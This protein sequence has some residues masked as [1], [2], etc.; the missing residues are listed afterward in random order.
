M[1]PEAPTDVSTSEAQRRTL[2]LFVAA[3]A[4][5]GIGVL[6]GR[7]SAPKPLPAPSSVTVIRPTPSVITAL[8]DIAKL[9]SASCHVERVIDLKD[10]QTRFFG[11]IHAEDAILLIASGDVVA[12]VDLGKL[13]DGD[14]SVDKD[15]HKAT[16]RLPAPEILSSRLDNENTYVHTRSTD[17][18]AQRKENLETEARKEAE[19]SIVE[20]A[21][22]SG[23]MDRAKNNAKRTV[24]SLVRSLGYSEVD[25]EFR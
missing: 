14:V 18:L 2:V 19:K 23:L 7:F 8:H 20:A 17:A 22:Q 6:L 13:V 9:E 4:A 21:K 25:V 5:L 12:G 1:N 16:V 3:L 15:R 10:K 24:E 11:L